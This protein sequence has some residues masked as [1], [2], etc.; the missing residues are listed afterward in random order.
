[1]KLRRSPWLASL[2]FLAWAAGALAQAPPVPAQ[3]F[4]TNAGL[5]VTDAGTWKT[6]H[7]GVEYRKVT[8]ERREPY[9]I[10]DL[11]LVRFDPHGCLPRVIRSET[12]HLKGAN[13]RTLAEKS[14]ALAAINA[15]Y[16]DPDGRPLGFLKALAQE[17]NRHISKSDLLTGVFAV[18][19]R[20]PFI[21]HRDQFAPEQADEGLQAGPL[22]IAKSAPL[23]V[24]RGAERQF[25]RSLVGIDAAQRIVIAATDTLLGGLTWL[26][27]QEFFGA[28]QWRVQAV[29]LLNLDGGGST[30][31]YVRAAPFE[32]NVAGA[33]EVPVALGFFKLQ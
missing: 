30:Q 8:L 26:E 10:I 19:D 5:A 6:V 12:Y 7:K 20:A 3:K 25:R 2:P 27:L 16:F 32:E 33:A 4:K 14:G 1:M 28:S 9:Q 15:N 21:V 23:T 13:V 17:I 11:K 24:T 18:K 22:L 29:D 31:L